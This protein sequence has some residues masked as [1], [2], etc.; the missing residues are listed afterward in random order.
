MDDL[1][2]LT[3]KFTTPITQEEIEGDFFDYLK[4][5]LVIFHMRLSTEKRREFMLMGIL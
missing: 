5:F 2:E 3:I 4:K 1:D